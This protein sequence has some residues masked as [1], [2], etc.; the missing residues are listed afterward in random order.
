[1]DIEVITQLISNVG[2]P[3]LAFL[4]MYKNNRDMAA[5]HQNE[6]HELSKVIEANTQATQKLVDKIGK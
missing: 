3:I 2:F 1:M 5:Q 6:V 4:L